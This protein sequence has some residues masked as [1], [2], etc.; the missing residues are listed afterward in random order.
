MCDHKNLKCTNN[1][2]TCKD[3]GAVLPLEALAGDVAD[4][5]TTGKKKGGKG[6]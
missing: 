3:C 1:V 2:L 4:K 6:K 5:V